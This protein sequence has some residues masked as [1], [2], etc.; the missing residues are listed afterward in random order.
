VPWYCK[1]CNTKWQFALFPTIGM[2]SRVQSMP[3]HE[4]ATMSRQSL[5]AAEL[6][7]L[8]DRARVDARV[9]RDAAIADFW[10]GAMVAL[11]ASVS[12]AQ[13]AAARLAHRPLS[14][15]RRRSVSV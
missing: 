15:S 14:H 11:L 6:N 4:E 10:R 13:R 7:R 5:S 8:H 1:N 3:T 12:A 2:P 9:Q